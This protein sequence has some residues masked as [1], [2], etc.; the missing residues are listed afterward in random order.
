ML[1]VTSKPR[2]DRATSYEPPKV[3]REGTS[4]PFHDFDEGPCISNRSSNFYFGSHDPFVS[5]ESVDFIFLV[6]DHFFWI[7]PVKSKLEGFSFKKYGSPRKP[8]L[9]SVEEELFEK[10]IVVILRHSPLFIVISSVNG[11]AYWSPRT[12]EF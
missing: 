4:S 12:R 11:I 8:C 5:E 2:N 10:G 3:I 6:S 7:K 9:K 1:F